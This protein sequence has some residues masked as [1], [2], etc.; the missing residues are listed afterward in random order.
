M[1]FSCF[2]VLCLTFGINL[3]LLKRMFEFQGCIFNPPFRTISKNENGELKNVKVKQVPKLKYLGNLL[4]EGG[5]Y[6]NE[7]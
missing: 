7:I 1:R 5:K 4:T 6:D 3:L 2:L